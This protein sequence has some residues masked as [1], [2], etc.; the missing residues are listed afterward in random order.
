MRVSP[1]W[2]GGTCCDKRN[3]PGLYQSIPT[4]RP[5]ISIFSS[6]WDILSHKKL[7]AMLEQSGCVA[8]PGPGEIK[9]ARRLV[10]VDSAV[11]TERELL[12]NMAF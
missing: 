3:I 12:R 10:G 8:L 7:V 1:N 2:C 5:I 9:V 4:K 11:S 6:A